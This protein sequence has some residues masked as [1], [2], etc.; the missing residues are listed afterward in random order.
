MCWDMREWKAMIRPTD[1]PQIRKTVAG[2]DDTHTHAMYTH[3]ACPRIV[4]GLHGATTFVPPPI[5]PFGVTVMFSLC[6][7][8]PTLPS[9]EAIEWRK[10]QLERA[11]TPPPLIPEQRIMG[12]VVIVFFC[13]IILLIKGWYLMCRSVSGRFTAFAKVKQGHG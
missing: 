10:Q 5:C 9:K 8:F 12:V 13:L 6:S 2:Y 11:D 3:V 4:W 7:F 1:C